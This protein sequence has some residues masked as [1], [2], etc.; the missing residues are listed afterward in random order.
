MLGAEPEIPDALV[1][2]DPGGHGCGL[3]EITFVM[4]L[5]GWLGLR[6][7]AFLSAYFIDEGPEAQGWEELSGSTG[8]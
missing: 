4:A 5:W 8:E 3:A 2:S 7:V 1:V 6:A